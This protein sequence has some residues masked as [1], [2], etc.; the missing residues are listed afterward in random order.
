[1]LLADLCSEKVRIEG[2]GLMMGLITYG[3]GWKGLHMEVTMVLTFA[4]RPLCG[5]AFLANSVWS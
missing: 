2:L 3:I 4:L 1:M 5:Y